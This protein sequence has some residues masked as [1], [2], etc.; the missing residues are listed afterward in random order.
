MRRTIKKE[1]NLNKL[2][3]GC[4]PCMKEGKIM[5]QKI[6]NREISEIKIK[7]IKTIISSMFKKN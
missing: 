7:E 4:S 3:T 6:S 2:K 5:E 1:I